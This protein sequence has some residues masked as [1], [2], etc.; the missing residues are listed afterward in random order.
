M[1]RGDRHAPKLRLDRGFYRLRPDRRHVEPEILPSLRRFHQDA[2]QADKAQ[3]TVGAH[4]R[5]AREHGVGAFGRLDRQ[6]PASGDNR[7]LPRVERR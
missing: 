1:T 4:L 3:P 7:A 6:H 5:D 2:R